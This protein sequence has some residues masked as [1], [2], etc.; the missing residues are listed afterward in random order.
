MSVGFTRHYVNN[1]GANNARSVIAADIDGDSDLDIA[2]ASQDDHALRWYQNDGQQSFT[3]RD[4]STSV[5]NARDVEA[6]DIDGDG[7]VD[8]LCA[9][10]G[11]D[12]AY[13]VDND[14]SESFAF[15]CIPVDYVQCNVPMDVDGDAL[16]RN[17]TSRRL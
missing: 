17:Q 6:L 4:I 1:G 10:S 16:G 7:D 3:T 13:F 11:D 9:G 14:G 5:T 15:H 2:S 8:L 12:C